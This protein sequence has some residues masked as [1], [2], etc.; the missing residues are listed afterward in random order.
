MTFDVIPD[1]PCICEDPTW[2]MQVY[3]EDVLIEEA[4]VDATT[5]TDESATDV[6]DHHHMIT[7]LA[8]AMGKTWQVRVF[9]PGCRKGMA[10]TDGVFEEI[11]GE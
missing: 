6:R 1:S 4:I 8:G 11:S 3:V 9:C 10:I 5:S 7:V 2:L